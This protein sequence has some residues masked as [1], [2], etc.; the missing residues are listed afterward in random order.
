MIRKWSYN[1][2][3]YVLEI[4]KGDPENLLRGPDVGMD[5]GSLAIYALFGP[6]PL[7]DVVP[8]KLRCHQLL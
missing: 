6:Q 3:I 4:G 1:V 5:L 2:D 8:D 7:T